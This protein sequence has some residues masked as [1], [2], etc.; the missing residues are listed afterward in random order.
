[1]GA[2]GSPGGLRAS[3]AD[4]EQAIETVKAAFTRGHLTM[5]DLDARVGLAL[6]ARTCAELSAVTAG[7]RAESDL[8]RPREAARAQLRRTR[9]RPVNVGA[10]VI[11]VTTLVGGVWAGMVAGAAAAVL[12]AIFMLNL[13][14]LA[15][16]P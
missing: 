6:T 15:T 3:H 1:V 16:R 2:A 4:R 12:V 13:A 14:A 11:T 8:A 10:W 7:I 9:T 5:D